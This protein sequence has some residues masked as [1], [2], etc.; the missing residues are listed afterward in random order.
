MTKPVDTGSGHPLLSRI[1][2]DAAGDAII[3]SSTAGLAIECNE[4]AL[5]FFGCTREQF[6]GSSPLTWSPEFQPDGR[7]SDVAAAEYFSQATAGGLTCFEWQNQRLD[8][9]PITVEATVRFAR[10]A[11]EDLFIIVSRDISERKRA[12]AQDIEAQE[13]FERITKLVPGMVYQFKLRPDGIFCMPYVS[14]A[15]HALFHLSPEEVRD[16][17]SRLIQRT[18]PDDLPAL[19]ASIQA[20]ARDLTPWQHE[21]RLKYDDGSVCWVY[22]T[23]VPQLESD[24]SVLWHGFVT[25]I[26]KS[27]EFETTLQRRRVM[28]ERTE[29]IA[30]LASFEW[31]VD[32]NAVTWSPEMFQLFGR[33][34]ALGIPNLEGQAELYTPASTQILIDAVSK[35]VSQGTPYTVELMTVQPDGEQRPCIARGFPERDDSGRVVRV[36]GLVQ[37]ITAHKEAQ[38]SLIASEERWKFAIEG[39]GDGLWDWNVQT[40]EAFYSTRYKQMYGYADEDFGTTGK[41]WSD[42]IH[43]EDAPGVFAALQPYM[44]GK[45]GSAT[46]EFR[47]LCKDGSWLWTM[48]RGMVVERDSNGKSVRM[49]GTNADISLN[50]RAQE[51]LQLAAGVFTHALEGIV[52]TTPDATIIDVNDAF[53]QIT[54]YSREEVIGRNPRILSSG[55]HDSSF[56]SVMWAA[57]AQKGHWSGEVWN[58]RKNGDIYPEWLSISSV[59]DGNGA[60]THCVGIFTDISERKSDQEQIESLAFY[61]P[62]TRLPNRRLMLDRLAQALH[63]GARHTSKGALLFVDLDNFKTINDTLGHHQ[64]DLLL[65]QVAQRLKACVREGDTVARLGSDEF[66]VMIEDLSD[67]EQD[68]ANEAETVGE[69]ILASLSQ[70]YPLADGAHHSTACIGITLFGGARQESNEE[71]LKRA[72]LAMFQA[73]AVGRNSMRFFDA[74]MQAQVS[75]HAALEADLRGGIAANQFLLYYQPQVVGAGHVTGV[76]A[77]LRWQHPLRGL[78]SPAEFIPL[79]EETGLILPIGQWV[80]EAACNQLIAWANDPVLCQ[81][82]VA[83][84]V[85]ALQFQQ[86]DFVD[87]VLGIL[88]RTGAT[89]RLLKLELTESML[90]D[91]VENV[92][93]KMGILKA[94]GVC[95]SLDDFGTGY[96]SLAY[97]K[98]LPLDQLKIDQGFVQNIV[99]DSNDAAI[100]KMVVALA[101]S[102]GL[103]V[104]AEGVEM[105]AHAD[106][107][108][109]LGCLAYQ[110]YLFGRPMP[111]AAFETF[112]RNR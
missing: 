36:A 37:D 54:G 12:A 111:V 11:G 74:Q 35:A 98:R 44:D 82:T 33:D 95:F 108:A 100:A 62:L 83:V 1:Y 79:A 94:H 99:S 4:T 30:R 57:L 14:E 71:P 103:S 84:N 8:G 78:V 66:V 53:A 26:S 60:A 85:S 73:K 81:L 41:E 112:A 49:I 61:D 32:T 22:G 21:Y 15:I 59:K 69:K 88:K 92:I 19:I 18:H 38:A 48:G 46:V 29:S 77:L 87:S 72:E 97:L 70:S 102:L 31:D 109:Q 75:A 65:T 107:L 24:G 9:T 17:A 45:P 50:K 13:R 64:G 5:T 23:S 63:T 27:K 6:I 105:Q 56:Y 93:A 52:I 28:M 34:P 106:F 39:A 51:K 90:V 3:A 43:P 67:D 68:A 16:D 2:F 25:D 58:R 76:E 47:M 101:N 91:D 55:R 40:G 80:I 86:A 7:R 42:R 20:S 89:P 110:G 10:V 104:I 96:S